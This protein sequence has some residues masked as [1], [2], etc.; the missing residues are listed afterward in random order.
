MSGTCRS[1][2]G[3]EFD[4]WPITTSPTPAIRPA[5]RL[6][7]ATSGP[8]GPLRIPTRARNAHARGLGHQQKR[9]YRIY[10][11]LGLQLRNK[12]AEAAC[13]G[14]AA[15]RPEDAV[16][17]KDGWRWISSTMSS[18][19]TRR[20]VCSIRPIEPD[21]GNPLWQPLSLITCFIRP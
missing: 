20:S 19:P 3:L 13:E 10:R 21:G 5:S 15:A 6:G 16:C 9:T 17:Q 14:E 2:A 18:L 7:S 12:D 11:D 8:L 1:G 4:T